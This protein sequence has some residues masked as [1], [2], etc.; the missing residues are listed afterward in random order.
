MFLLAA[1]CCAMSLV[2]LKVFTTIISVEQWHRLGWT[3]LLP[4][5]SMRAEVWAVLC[6][7]LKLYPLH[8]KFLA[9]PC[10][11]A[12]DELLSGPAE[13][14]LQLATQRLRSTHEDICASLI[15][16]GS[17]LLFLQ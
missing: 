3:L 14:F 8:P 7:L 13:R 16:K 5:A 17:R 9:Y 11:L 2:K 1:C 12:G 6:S 15:K 10:V 4:S